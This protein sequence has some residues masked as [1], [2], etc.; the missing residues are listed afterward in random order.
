MG[1]LCDFEVK[2]VNFNEI[3]KE[4]NKQ[5]VQDLFDI[6]RIQPNFEKQNLRY[7][8]KGFEVFDRYLL[9]NNMFKL[10]E[11]KWYGLEKE[12]KMLS[13]QNPNIKV[14]IYIEGADRDDYRRVFVYKGEVLEVRAEVKVIFDETKKSW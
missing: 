5:F 1:Y 7:D 9:P 2:L 8:K 10:F 12:L 11:Y 4:E 13:R 3:S 14:E 6:C